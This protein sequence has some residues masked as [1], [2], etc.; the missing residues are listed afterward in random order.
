M[1]AWCSNAFD[2]LARC[3]Y[4]YLRGANTQWRKIGIRVGCRYMYMRD[5]VPALRSLLTSIS[6]NTKRTY[7]VGVVENFTAYLQIQENTEMLDTPADV[8][9]NMEFLEKYR[10][11]FIR[12]KRSETLCSSCSDTFSF[13]KLSKVSFIRCAHRHT[14]KEWRRHDFVHARCQSKTINRGISVVL[15]N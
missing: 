15:H 13:L 9:D 7:C 2:I 5:V 3:C 14:K 6:P 10:E 1:T 11:K 8:F 4:L 12:K